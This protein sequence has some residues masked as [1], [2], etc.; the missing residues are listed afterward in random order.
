M[1]FAA[2]YVGGV[3]ALLLFALAF[4]FDL[5]ADDEEERADHASIFVLVVLLW[6]LVLLLLA[7]RRRE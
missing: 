2:M 6:P 3:A 4:R 1:E 7:V 5:G